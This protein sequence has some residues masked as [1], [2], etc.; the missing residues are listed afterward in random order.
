[1]SGSDFGK[2]IRSLKVLLR[3]ARFAAVLCHQN[4][5]PDAVCSAFALSRLLR[6]LNR[7]IVVDLKAP[8]GVS[9]VS[10]AVLEHVPAKFSTQNSIEEADLIFMVDTSTTQQLGRL[11]SKVEN[12]GKPL[13]LIDHHTPHPETLQLASLKI[14]DDK[15]TSACEIIYGLYRFFGIKPARIEASAML[16]GTI[17]E[18]R[19]FKIAKTSTFL[20]TAGLI[21]CGAKVEDVKPI[22]ELP[23]AESERIAR[24]KAAQRTEVK[25]YRSWIVAASRLSSYQASAARALVGL[26]AHVAIVSG[27]KNDSLRV[28]L[29][30]SSDF[31]EKTN[32]HLGKDVAIP[33]GK[34]FGMGGGHALAAGINGSGD[35]DKALEHCVRTISSKLKTL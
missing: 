5:D 15:A 27:G 30:S 3:N 10:E 11:K 6:R 24:L 12:S 32:I 21:S 13:V 17:Y 16:I 2:R 18:T 29:R 14:V 34:Q 23:M 9:K 31:Y 4:A 8:S 1:L 26:G 7:S 25:R 19:H 20:N 35:P 22:L 33:V 28:S